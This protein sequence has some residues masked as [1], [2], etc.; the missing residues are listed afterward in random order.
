MDPLTIQKTIEELM[1]QYTWWFV[2]GAS[3]LFFKSAIENL[4]SGLMFYFGSDYNVDDV[5]FIYGRK[6][7]RIVRQT[8]TKTVFYLTDTNRRLVV[9]NRS[10]SS[11]GIEKTLPVAPDVET[12]DC[13][14]HRRRHEREE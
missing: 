13:H 3:A 6:K 9:P 14:D 4:V 11:M 12:D 2:G 7:A 8:F 10:L 5:V 1:S